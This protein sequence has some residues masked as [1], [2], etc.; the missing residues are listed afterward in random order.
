MP[1]DEQ[2]TGD[3]S[4][5][6]QRKCE[7][8]VRYA[9]RAKIPNAN[10]PGDQDAKQEVGATRQQLVRKRPPEPP[11][12]VP[13]TL[14]GEVSHTHNNPANPVEVPWKSRLE[15]VEALRQRGPRVVMPG[16]AVPRK[17]WC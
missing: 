10:G 11:D 17:Q 9:E 4:N 13:S 1:D 6:S 14:C 8:R 3:G 12:Q 15:N 5:A 2:L 16:S 7:R